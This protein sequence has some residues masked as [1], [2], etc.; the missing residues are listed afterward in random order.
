MKKRVLVVLLFVIVKVEAQTSTFTTIDSLFTKGR[1]KLAL[2]ALEKINPPSF[3][4]NY[5]TAVIYESIDNY[6]K[7]AQFLEN[8]LTFKEDDK[9]N[10]K[11]KSI[12]TFTKNK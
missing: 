6:Q 1:Y 12:S 8:S 4:S 9:A 2:V 5:K 11:L 10:L 3:L 7:T